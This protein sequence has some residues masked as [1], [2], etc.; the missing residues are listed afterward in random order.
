MTKRTRELV[1]YRRIKFKHFITFPKQLRIQ[2]L[3]HR[4]HYLSQLIA[5]QLFMH[6]LSTMCKGSMFKRN[7]M[8]SCQL[9]KGPKLIQL[10]WVIFFSR[11]FY[12]SLEI[13]ELRLNLKNELNNIILMKNFKEKST[14]VQLCICLISESKCLRCK[15]ILQE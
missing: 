2:H 7:F 12:I 11:T 6:P 15:L 1:K 13:K 9:L 8:V 4:C 10:H 14:P 5:I 3:A